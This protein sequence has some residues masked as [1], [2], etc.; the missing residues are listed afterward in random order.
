MQPSCTAPASLKTKSAPSKSAKCC[1][2]AHANVMTQSRVANS[3][4]YEGLFAGH[5]VHTWEGL[6]RKGRCDMTFGWL[7]P[8]VYQGFACLKG[9]C[10]SRAA[11]H[12]ATCL[13]QSGPKTQTCGKYSRRTVWQQMATARFPK[14][15]SRWA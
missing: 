9:S 15:P 3:F 10:V 7:K 13:A 1:S 4:R 12:S 8:L 6:K 5:T 11:Q 14:S 2:E